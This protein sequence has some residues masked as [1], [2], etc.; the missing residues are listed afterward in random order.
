MQKVV[1]SLLFGKYTSEDITQFLWG[2]MSTSYE[3]KI[4]P[5]DKETLGLV[6]KAKLLNAC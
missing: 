2:P 4:L 3:S 1:N 5:T 6:A